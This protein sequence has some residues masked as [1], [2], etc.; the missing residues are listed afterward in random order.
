MGQPLP[1]TLIS[2]RLWALPLWIPPG[3][4]PRCT[5]LGPLNSQPDSHDPR[6]LQATSSEKAAGGPWT[7][8]R[9]ALALASVP[10]VHLP[11]SLARERRVNGDRAQLSETIEAPAPTV[12]A[13]A[14]S[15]L[16]G[17][18]RKQGHLQLWAKNLPQTGPGISQTSPDQEPTGL[19]A[20]GH[21]ST[22]FL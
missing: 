3:E 16:L 20:R 15:E 12:T 1:V 6:P 13:R 18:A 21:C 14:R 4:C 11:Q 2:S 19:D 10:Q 7:L 5:H 9:G 17:G 8:G 22:E